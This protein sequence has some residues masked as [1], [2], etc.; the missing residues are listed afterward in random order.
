MRTIVTSTCPNHESMCTGKDVNG[1]G[2]PIGTNGDATE[3]TDQGI[4]KIV[5]AA[6]ILK[7]TYTAD[8]VKCEMGAIAYA[9]NGVSIFSGAVE[10]DCSILDVEDDVAEWTSFDCC[11]G[12]S[13]LSGMYH[14]HFP[15]SCLLA[16]L[17]DYGD[18]HSP[19]IGWSY[20][21]FPIYGPLGPGGVEIMNCGVDGADATYCQDECGGYEGELSGVDTYTYRYYFTGKTSD[22]NALPSDPKPDS[23]ELYFP[24]TINCYRGCT[25]DE[26]AAGTCAGAA[27]TTDAH[28][29]E[30]HPGVTEVLGVQCTD[31][32]YYADYVAG[33]AASPT[34][35]PV[36]ALAGAC[37]SDGDWPFYCTEAEAVA[38]SPDGTAHAMG[39]LYMPDGVSMVM[40]G[41]YAG[42]A[43]ACECGSSDDSMA[44][45]DHGHDH[46]DHDDSM[47]M[48]DDD[49]DALNSACAA[50][51][52]AFY[53]CLGIEE[54]AD[55][56]DGDDDDGDDDWSPTSCADAT[57][58]DSLFWSHCEGNP[59]GDQ[60]T[61]EWEAYVECIFT[62]A[63]SM[64]FGLDC[65]FEC[66][67]A[68]ESVAGSM[69]VSG[70]SLE[71]AEAQ[72]AVFVAAIASAAGVADSA[73]AVTFAASSRR[74]LSAG[75][76]IAYTIATD[77]TTTDTVLAD[78]AA[79]T[80]S[81]FDSELATAAADAGESATF[82]A[83]ATEE[84]T[85]PEEVDSDLSGAATLG[86][87]GVAALVAALAAL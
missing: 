4:T 76:D 28:V 83:V 18:G 41:T 38:V 70:I 9:L 87:A 74:K 11:S 53:A 35:A 40:D 86:V 78:M 34:A 10:S 2:Y 7:T 46:D 65:G 81:D 24:F 66:T 36:D 59:A 22:L 26:M 31:G 5:P 8:D 54:P 69:S 79:L 42:D 15:P 77:S 82:A 62:A 75:V 43:D 37:A 68:E 61:D 16:Q 6:P 64:G 47:A 45:D 80:A 57:A 17:D 60:C 39:D 44:M 72:A 55:D 27:G 56:D 51:V 30:A 14:Y 67:V 49:D 63:A 50:N 21:G 58:A 85:A 33:A 73:V 23:A 12:H 71:D 52:D 13:E 32:L 1:C 84:I 48:D 19:Q 20:D 3:A 29:A 25:Y